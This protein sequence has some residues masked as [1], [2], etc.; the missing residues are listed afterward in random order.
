MPV[1][2]GSNGVFWYSHNVANV[3]MVVISTEHDVSPSSV[4]AKWLESDLAAVNRTRQPWV[5]VGG[6]RSLY[7]D[8]QYTYPDPDLPYQEHGR[9]YLTPLFDHYNVNVYLAG[10]YHNYVRTCPL[11]VAGTTH[12]TVGTG[13]AGL[14]PDTFSTPSWI[15]FNLTGYH[16]FVTFETASSTMA[17]L[18]F[19][20]AVS[21]QMMDNT[22]LIQNIDHPSSRPSPETSTRPTTCPAS[23][24]PR[25]S[26]GGIS[27][28]GKE[29]LIGTL[30]ALAGFMLGGVSAVFI[31]K[32]LKKHRYRT[33]SEF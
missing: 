7:N 13:G 2:P 18:K 8:V 29:I 6:H 28:T 27:Q 23:V 20:D 12:I 11:I 15:A 1:S 21:G 5:I 17:V 32:K 9:R 16:G 19:F 25:P 26:N 4:Q 3:H 31:L 30:C 14:E 33:V 24:S 22:T 10:H